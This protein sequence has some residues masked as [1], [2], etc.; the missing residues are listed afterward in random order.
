MSAARGRG[1]PFAVRLAMAMCAAVA[2][3]G[4]LLIGIYH[5]AAKSQA[6]ITAAQ[7]FE[8]VA[9][10][11]AEEVHGS[12]NSGVPAMLTLREA[13]AVGRLPIND[14]DA[15]L[16]VLLGTIRANPGLSW[17]SYADP[18][19]RFVGVTATEGGKLGTNVSWIKT[20]GQT[21]LQEA[22]VLA[23]NSRRTTHTDD[24]GAYDPRQ[25]KFYTDAVAYP[26]EL[27]WQ[28]PYMF[29]G[30][31]LP[32]VTCST[33]VTV[34]GKPAGVLTIDF[35]LSALRN[36]LSTIKL[37]QDARLFVVTETDKVVAIVDPSLKGGAI[38]LPMLADAAPDVAKLVSQQPDDSSTLLHASVPFVVTA[39][40]NWRVIVVAP[41]VDFLQNAY[42][43]ER[44]LAL[45]S[46]GVLGL[47]LLVAIFL[48]RRVSTPVNQLA[49]TMKKIG[50]G[51]L[52]ATAD[53]RGAREF[54][55]LSQTLNKMVADLRDGVRLKHSIGIAMQVQKRLL[56]ECPP[57]VDGL[58]I[59]GYSQYC[60]ETG[61]DY[62]DF[63][64]VDPQR[65]QQLMIVVG[66]V[67]GHGIG[68]ALVMASA[69]AVLRD[70]AGEVGNLATLL[71]RLN[72]MVGSDTQ[73][74]QFMTMLVGVID[75][76]ERTYRFASAGHDP[77]IIY[78]RGCDQF[79]EIDEAGLP[80]G[81]ND[82]GMYVEAGPV[83]LEPGD[84]IIIGTD[85][86]WEAHTTASDELFGRERLRECVRKHAAEGVSAITDAVVQAICDFQEG[87]PSHD[88]VTFVVIKVVA[89]SNGAASLVG[90]KNE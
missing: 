45:S 17:V 89:P 84:V 7:L 68:S 32:G 69:R 27:C 88:D 63:L 66:D 56:P 51:D 24:H 52:T 3:S 64:I 76:A 15:L 42:R 38:T 90:V 30:Q 21:H 58:E 81:V 62:Y 37:P 54:V 16:D 46:A 44:M 55:N 5:A 35:T 47:S 77:A 20:D 19:G 10:R 75:A 18:A 11:A 28:E 60:D 49:T 87:C 9:Q 70:R 73:G 67:T 4:L 65:P 6:R 39:K 14:N 59:A 25:R 33:A 29:Y 82:D 23:D 12:I 48:A 22:D 79:E 40:Q 83:P 26:D 50:G 36:R 72:S 86:V 1:W 80:L 71:D 8:S 57:K 41:A 34:G 13:A 31:N 2:V 61:G 78:R 74:R 85:G 53:V 43:T